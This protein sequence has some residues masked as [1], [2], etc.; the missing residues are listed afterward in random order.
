MKKYGRDNRPY[1][2]PVKRIEL[3]EMN[4][5]LRWILI[6]VLLSIAVVSIMIGLTSML[7]TEPGWQAVEV[8]S[9]QASCGGDFVFQYDFTDYGS[10]A[11]A[12]F[13]AL[14]TVYSDAAVNG[15]R[16]FSAEVL[17]DGLLNVAYLNAHVNEDVAV[18]PALYS[19]LELVAKYGDR[20]VFT[21]PAIVEYNRM[22]LCETEAEAALYNPMQ[23]PETVGWLAELGTY[24]GDP[25]HIKL[26]ILG[27]NRVRLQVSEEYLAFAEEN[28]IET[29]LDF[30]WMKN[31]FLADY[32]AKVLT[33]AGFTSGNLTSYDGFTRNL[34]ERGVE[35]GFNIFDRKGS[36][37]NMPV[38]MHYSAPMSIVFL[39]DYPMD[40]LDRW[41]YFAFESGDVVTAFLDAKDGLSKSAIHNLVSYSESVG[42]AE[43][44]LQTVQVFVAD[45]FRAEILDELKEQEIFS[46]WF[47]DKTLRYNDAGLKLEASSAIGSEQYTQIP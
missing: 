13:K 35:Y 8:S 38:V 12:Q 28:D 37:I 20:H 47:E 3:S 34:D 7:N 19:A 46:V 22:F 2:K 45:E 25:E 17:E 1:V 40:E 39:R 11:T 15:Y 30:G 4:T 23:N 18:D 24:M 36:S 26:E 42:C 33:E 6:V 21:A 32:L 41:H 14:T 10:G 9:D 44:L 27:N 43:I 5:K 29:F 16:V 31:A